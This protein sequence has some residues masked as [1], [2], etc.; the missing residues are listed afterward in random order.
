METFIVSYD[1][2]KP[3]RWRRVHRILKDYGKSLQYSVF[4]CEISRLKLVSLR[5]EL[6]NAI[7]RKKDRVL[8]IHLC[9][10]C[11]D[12]IISL[13]QPPDEPTDQTIIA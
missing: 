8:I 6:A 5:E 2:R 12:G 7:D 4:R 11:I 10:D 9:R 3:A 13:G 1:I